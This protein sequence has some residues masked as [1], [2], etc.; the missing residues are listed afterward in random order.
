MLQLNPNAHWK[1]SSGLTVDG[2]SSFLG[3]RVW[4]AQYHRVGA[5]YVDIR[6]GVQL[7]S[8]QLKLLNVFDMKASRGESNAAELDV[9]DPPDL[10]EGEEVSYHQPGDDYWEKFGA[11]LKDI[12]D[13]F[14]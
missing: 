5:K 11:E 12:E 2:G 4:A 14:S 9:E 6:D 10:D 3:D 1:T 8:K 7:H 13:E